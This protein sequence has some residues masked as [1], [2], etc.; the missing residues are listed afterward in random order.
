[1][2]F[3]RAYAAR[4]Q[5][6]PFSL[7]I[8]K[9]LRKLQVG[10]ALGKVARAAVGFVPGIGPI[11]AQLMPPEAMAAQAEAAQLPPAGAPE[12]DDENPGAGY[13]WMRPPAGHPA[14]Q[15]ARSYGW[16]MGDPGKVS[17]RKSAA[18]G[19][20]AKAAKKASNRAAKAA[21]AG[22]GRVKGS[23]ARGKKGGGAGA[24]LSAFG[25]SALEAAQRTMQS[26]RG[27]PGAIMSQA[28]DFSM[29]GARAAGRGF[30]GRRRS[31]NPANVHALK[32]G[33]RRLEGFEKLVKRIERQYP[34][35]KRAV[36]HAPS[37]ARGHK[38]GCRCVACK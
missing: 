5:G 38:A 18:A 27:G 20:R 33:L 4:D 30:G 9:R 19:P 24:F 32:R 6:D 11:A 35:I 13:R 2:A 26:A 28:F 22:S 36:G 10:R 8:P 17:K 7:R 29:P 16:D 31:M 14:W 12:W 37:G 34:R 3:M 25:S 15:F 23:S 21:S 1:M